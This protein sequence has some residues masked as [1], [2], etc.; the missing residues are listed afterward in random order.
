MQLVI[1][2]EGNGERIILKESHATVRFN[3]VW[4]VCIDIVIVL[5]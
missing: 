4:Y 3:G 1:S 2:S 5:S